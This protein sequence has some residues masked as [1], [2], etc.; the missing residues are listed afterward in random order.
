VACT[1][2]QFLDAVRECPGLNKAK[3][4]LGS[5]KRWH[6]SRKA[7]PSAAHAARCSWDILGGALVC[8]MECNAQ[9]W[10]SLHGT[11]ALRAGG[12]DTSYYNSLDASND[13]NTWYA[14]RGERGGMYAYIYTH[15]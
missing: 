11:D 5:F 4:L 8:R 6:K 13:N 1:A 12:D 9:V 14:V 7:G 10:V 3:H 15:I 2:A